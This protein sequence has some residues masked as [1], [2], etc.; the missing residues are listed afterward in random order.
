MPKALLV[1]LFALVM[2]AGAAEKIEIVAEVLSARGDTVE[3]KGDVVVYYGDAIIHSK[4]ARYDRKKELLTLEGEQIDLLGLEGKKIQSRTLEIETKAKILHFKDVLLSTDNDIWVYSDNARKS[5]A[6]I[7]FGELVMSSCDMNNSDWKLHAGSS[8]Y[9]DKEKYMKL[10]DVALK[11]WDV[12]LFYTPYMAFDT[13]QKRS[14]GLLFPTFG[15]SQS[16]GFLYEQPVYWAASKS[17]D[18]EFN[19]QVRTGRGEGIY[20]TL[21][22]LDS[23]TSG[24]RIRLGYFRDNEEYV[25]EYNLRNDV[26]YGA[27]ILYHSDHLLKDTFSTSEKLREG[28]YIN[29]TLL[30]DIEY[31][32]LQKGQRTTFG[33]LPIQESKL[34]YFLHDDDYYLGLYSKYFIDTRVEDNNATVQQLPKLQIHKYLKELL[35]DD[36]TY[37]INFSINNLT[38]EDGVTVRVAQAAVPLEYTRS[39]LDDY[40]SLSLSEDIYYDDLAYDGEMLA[41]DTYRSL[42]G[43]HHVELFSDLTRKYDSFV[44]VVQPSVSYNKPTYYHKSDIDFDDLEETQ[45]SLFTPV[46]TEENI[47]FKLSHFFY[48]LGGNL[49]F[50]QRIRQNY[51]TDNPREKWGDISNE[52]EYRL[53]E[54]KLYNYMVYSFEFDKI[55][56]SVSRVSW[57]Q[58]GHKITLAHSYERVFSWNDDDSIKT[59]KKINDI[60]LSGNYRLSDRWQLTGGMV[61]NL[62]KDTKTQWFTGFAYRRDCWNLMLRLRRDI[63][64]SGD[65]SIQENSFMFQLNLVPFGGIGRK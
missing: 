4:S 32:N 12:P 43:V 10:H 7:N 36:L 50:Y 35:W 20:A 14:S 41:N 59:Q 22:F 25:S 23:A 5:D 27:E 64:P 9:D 2:G 11:F 29:A 40:L 45:K 49:K 63:K 52:M 51:N 53:P 44:H 17:W 39:F 60:T 55:K 54:W 31:I 1:L 13:D 24:G 42:Q 62:D 34:N 8:E 18:V 28:I 3:A 58:W 16:E 56:E 48:D 46:D 65:E 21:R 6:G 61:Y 37:S 19:P 47:A 33:V 26:H 57:S 15:Y 30:N 38:R